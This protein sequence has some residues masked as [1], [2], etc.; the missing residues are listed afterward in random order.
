M[1]DAIVDTEDDDGDEDAEDN[2]NNM[3]PPVVRTWS[4]CFM[5]PIGSGSRPSIA[6]AVNSDAIQ[7]HRH[8]G[9]AVPFGAMKGS[10]REDEMRLKIMM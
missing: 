6:H 4:I 1:M 9:A 3:G 10:G 7:V 2:N 5:F 8:C